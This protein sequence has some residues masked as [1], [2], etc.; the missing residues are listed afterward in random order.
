MTLQRR[1][2]ASNKEV[3][4]PGCQPLCLQMV[5]TRGKPIQLPAPANPMETAPKAGVSRDGK[6]DDRRDV[7]EGMST[8][9]SWGLSTLMSSCSPMILVGMLLCSA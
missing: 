7:K 3:N 1:L 5:S 4:I 8:Q 2:P 6:R 9:P